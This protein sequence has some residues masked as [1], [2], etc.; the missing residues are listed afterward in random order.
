MKAPR[1]VSIHACGRCRRHMSE[2][3]N[4]FRIIWT[5]LYLDRIYRCRCFLR[6]PY[7]AKFASRSRTSGHP[8]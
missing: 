2:L 5:I 6:K 8:V 7:L 1:F 3:E 4:A